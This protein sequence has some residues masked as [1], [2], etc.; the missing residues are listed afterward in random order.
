MLKWLKK[1]SKQHRTRQKTVT[2][3]ADEAAKD[4]AEAVEE[5]KDAAED[6]VEQAEEAVKK[7]QMLRKRLLMKPPKVPKSLSRLLRKRPSPNPASWTK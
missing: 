3:A 5:A 1:P 6:A 2:D 4:A 7:P